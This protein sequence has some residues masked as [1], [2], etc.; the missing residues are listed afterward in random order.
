MLY[1]LIYILKTICN[2]FY[3]FDFIRSEKDLCLYNYIYIYIYIYTWISI[4]H[5]KLS[6]SS[7]NRSGCHITCSP[8]M[9]LNYLVY[10]NNASNHVKWDM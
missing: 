5:V 2:Y 4:C 10:M 9:Q 8:I 7:D 6:T 3:C 1:E